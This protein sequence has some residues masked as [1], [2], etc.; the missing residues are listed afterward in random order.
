MTKSTTK[1][2]KINHTMTNQ[3]I[4]QKFKNSFYRINLV[5]TKSREN[6]MICVICR[7]FPKYFPT[8][9][10]AYVYFNDKKLL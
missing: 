5:E 9:Y 6:G 3:E 7:E 2:T 8:Y 4:I 1:T 10:S